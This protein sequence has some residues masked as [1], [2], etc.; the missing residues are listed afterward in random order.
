MARGQHDNAAKTLASAMAIFESLGDRGGLADTLNEVGVLEE[1]R[2]RNTEALAQYRRALQIRR[3]IGDRRGE[4]ESLNNVGYA[5]QLLGESD[6]ASAYWEQALELHR[7]TG[8]REGVILVTQSLGQLEISQGK[9]D[10]AVKSFLSALDESREMELRSAAAASMG[11][12]GRLA[13][14]QGRYAAALSSY[15]EALA[16][17]TS[18]KDTHGLAE[19]TLARA[20]TLI[21]MGRI[22]EAEADLGRAGDY[23]GETPNVE[24]HAEWQRLR[25]TVRARRGDLDGTAAALAQARRELQG[26]ASP[27]SLLAV[28]VDEG[29]L[30]LQRGRARDAARALEN[31]EV[32]A[33]HL[34][35]VPLRLRAAEAA[36]RAAWSAGDAAAADRFVVLG[37][38]SVRDCGTWAGAIRLY[39]I[40]GA[41][42]KGRGETRAA[43][44]SFRHATQELDRMQQGLDAD[45]VSALRKAH[46]EEAS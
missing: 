18:L 31:I 30:Q 27:A 26:N 21:E 32:K 9:W 45:H 19:F 38:R 11:Y 3:E 15:A 44:A 41:L 23:L 8:N 20:E 36:A 14:Y 25:A 17:L 4:A 10:L 16:A 33:E 42:E 24:Q 34:G 12:L 7:E 40:Q 46:A 1:G 28:A 35:D 5:Y 43:E 2:G 29:L 37:L 6:N 39:R 22:D 13:Q